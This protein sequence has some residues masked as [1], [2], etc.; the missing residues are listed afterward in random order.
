MRICSHNLLRL[1][2]ADLEAAFVKIVDIAGG[3]T[4]DIWL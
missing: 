2:L 1:A 3:Y 4:P